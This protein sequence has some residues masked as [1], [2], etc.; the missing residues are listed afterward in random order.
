M[1]RIMMK[2]IKIRRIT[3]VLLILCLVCGHPAVAMAETAATVRMAK[4]EG[5]VK[6]SNNS[7]RELSL[8]QNMSL[9]NGYEVV[10]DQASYAWI[11]LDSTKLTKLDAISD[12]EL[13]KKG[14]QIELLL[15]SGNLYFNVTEPLEE[16]ETLNI[17]TSSMVMGI[18]GTAGWL[19]VIDRWHTRVYILEGEVLCHG[20]D[21]VSGQ[22]KSAVLRGGDLAEIVVYDQQKAGDKCD[23]IL[24]KF[25]E[26]DVDGFVLVELV[27]APGLCR[28]IYEDSGLE[29]LPQA[30]EADSRLSRD[31]EEMARKL[32][33]IRAKEE[34]QASQVS[35]DPVWDSQTS[36]NSSDS[37]G[38]SSSGSSSESPVQPEEPE[39]PEESDI[40]RLRMP[41]KAQVVHDTLQR[42]KVRQVILEPSGSGNPAENTLDVDVNVTVPSGKTL[43]MED[44]VDM[45][46]RGG[47]TLQIDGTLDM[48]GDVENNGNIQNTSSNTFRVGGV[49]SNGSTGT[50][51]NT[52]TGRIVAFGEGI[53]NRGT[54]DTSGTLEGAVVHEAGG[55][56]NSGT[57]TGDVTTGG[58]SFTNTGTVAGNAA[59]DGGTFTSQGSVTG[60]VTTGNGTFT[61]QGTLGEVRQQDGVVEIAGGTVTALVQTGG[62][63]G[64]S[65]G[66]VTVLTQTGGSLEVS[67]GTV[68][69][70]VQEN[71]EAK[72]SGGTVTALTQE[73]GSLGVSGG[74]VTALTQI[75]GRLEISGGTVETAVRENG[76]AEITGG[77]VTALTQTA[78]RLTASGGT[79]SRLEQNGG[80]AGIS[81]TVVI[82]DGYRISGASTLVMEG[83]TVKAGKEDAALTV[84]TVQEGLVPGTDGKIRLLV[85]TIDGGMKTGLKLV[86][87]D[88]DL[89]EAME[90][91]AGEVYRI[92]EMEPGSSPIRYITSD[93]ESRI[94]PDYIFVCQDDENGL[95][96]TRVHPNLGVTLEKARAGEIVT[97]RADG[98]MWGEAGE[99]D[100]IIISSGNKENPVY[101]DLNGKNLT[102]AGGILVGPPVLF[103]GTDGSSLDDIE[104]FKTG[105]LVIFDSG[106]TRGSLTVEGRIVNEIGSSLVL[107][108]VT[109]TPAYKDAFIHNRGDLEIQDGTVIEMTDDALGVPENGSRIID[110]RTESFNDLEAGH[111][112]IGTKGRSPV[113]II[114]Q[115]DQAE[116]LVRI[117]SLLRP[118]SL[119]GDSPDT[120]GMDE[121]DLVLDRV[122]IDG[123]GTAVN[124]RN[125]ASARITG[126]TE[127]TSQEGRALEMDYFAE[128]EISG[129][130]KL[131]SAAPG[132]SGTASETVYVVNNC[133]IHI[134]DDAR[135]LSGEGEAVYMGNQSSA[136]IDGNARLISESGNALVLDGPG[137][138]LDPEVHEDKARIEGNASLTSSSVTGTIYVDYRQMEAESFSKILLGKNASIVNESSGVFHPAVGLLTD[139]GESPRDLMEAFLAAGGEVKAKNANVVIWQTSS[140]GLPEDNEEW[141][142]GYEIRPDE[143][144]EYYH[145]VKSDQAL[146]KEELLEEP[147]KDAVIPEKP[148]PPSPATPSG[149]DLILDE[150][151]ELWE[152]ADTGADDDFPED[153][154]EQIL[155]TPSQ[156]SPVSQE[157]GQI[158]EH[159]EIPEESPSTE[160]IPVQ[161]TG[162]VTVQ[163]ETLGKKKGDKIG[164][165]GSLIIGRME[166]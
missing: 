100:R 35:V 90:M 39:E 49:L 98:R 28:Q 133:Q 162:L 153:R 24:R 36:Q 164:G 160:K 110:H 67:M 38:G 102:V 45:E 19:K 42:E 114:G 163:D 151:Q 101:L 125:Q 105:A 4:T 30:G 88:V 154:E 89:D 129:R 62:S 6:V 134:T 119:A 123:T 27:Q 115:I 14:R 33:E 9:Y 37:G 145:I 140:G 58:G 13:R 92:I 66:T 43:T 84:S 76:E 61:S 126:E 103:P 1:N 131:E 65:G 11:S 7:G 127:I 73:E 150:D 79:I 83:G 20:T 55:F 152:E 69:R 117:E 86:T 31:Q 136:I 132:N 72:V 56:T 138:Y 149:W 54:F 82:A 50:I 143:K 25:T 10:T 26:E 104:E 40:V 141:L 109:C 118:R 81:G 111:V 166:H 121:P 52:G 137:V 96:L 53:R 161:E 8:I 15:N 21:P 159:D 47:T 80:D 107:T 122:V 34:G 12:L 59:V 23:I 93:G 68:G 51:R 142:E 148:A 130:A 124:L 156:A 87:G 139:A 85:G 18:R 99:S 2:Q 32:E 146:L 165:A 46:T 97:A 113:R 17:R 44:G 22:R 78:G 29:I 48:A 108:G 64:V 120:R 147:Q 60:T 135:I 74:T 116:A 77:T 5:T 3:A 106:A 157:D 112:E 57:V 128:A 155:A 75:G 70:V 158:P 94:E 144:E 95:V 91:R 63:L 16:E 41:V 71:G